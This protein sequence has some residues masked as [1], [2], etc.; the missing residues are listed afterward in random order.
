MKDPC[1]KILTYFRTKQGKYISG[2]KLSNLLGVSRAYIWKNIN[3]LKEDGYVI[4]AVPHA[5]YMLKSSPDKLFG[6]EVQ[7]GLK[8]KA[9]GR[10]IDYNEKITSTNDRAYL[11]AEKNASEGTVVISESQTHGKGRMGRSWAS[12]VT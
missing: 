5:G 12:P 3:K 4:D 8:T 11:L 2:E 1:Q 9:F 6:Y 10:V 7:T